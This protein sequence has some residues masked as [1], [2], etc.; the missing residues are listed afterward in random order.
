M[1]KTFRVHGQKPSCRIPVYK[2]I[3]KT[4]ENSIRAKLLGVCII[5]TGYLASLE[6][7]AFIRIA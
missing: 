1:A 4:H 6:Q 5:K 3:N 2:S 7:K